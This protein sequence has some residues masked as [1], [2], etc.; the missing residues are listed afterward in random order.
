M[1]EVN[2]VWEKLVRYANDLVEV[3]SMRRSEDEMAYHLYLFP[4]GELKRSV[5]VFDQSQSGL[6]RLWGGKRVFAYDEFEGLRLAITQVFRLGRLRMVVLTAFRK[7]AK[8]VWPP[9]RLGR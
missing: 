4:K 8:V 7:E 5:R 1:S 3:R 2:P 9:R 6:D